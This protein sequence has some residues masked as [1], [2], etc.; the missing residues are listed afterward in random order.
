[1]NQ[2]AIAV[3]YAAVCANASAASSARVSLPDSARLGDLVEQ[4]AVAIRVADHAHRA[5]VLRRGADHRGPADVDRL[6]H[7]VARGRAA[8]RDPPERVQVDRDEVDRLDAE[9]GELLDVVRDVAPREEG[10]VHL[11]VQ[12]LDAALEHLGDAG[13]RLDPGDRQ[14][15]LLEERRGPRRRD[16][17]DPALVQPAREAVE[18]GLVR[19]RYAEPDEHGR[20]QSQ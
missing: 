4:E 20:R 17:L 16:Q 1:M 9:L 19:D 10:A 13:D 6:D 11:R 12:R 3:S 5:V 14:A 15:E 7:L 18:A 8:R 2:F